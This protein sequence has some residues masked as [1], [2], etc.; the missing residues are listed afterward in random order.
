[1]RSRA[2]FLLPELLCTQVVPCCTRVVSY[3]TLVVLVLPLVLL[4][5]SRVVLLFFLCFLVFY[6]VALA[7]YSQL[8]TAMLKYKKNRIQICLLK[9]SVM[10]F[11]QN[12]SYFEIDIDV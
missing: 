9:A 1:M 4:L 12:I 3:C 7:L 2:L 6:S 11:R 5:L 10:V 8:H